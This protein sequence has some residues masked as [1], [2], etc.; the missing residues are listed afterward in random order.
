[1]AAFYRLPNDL[2]T[3]ATCGSQNNQLHVTS[4]PDRLKVSGSES[5]GSDIGYR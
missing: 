3:G 4:L 1:M 2:Q 5:L